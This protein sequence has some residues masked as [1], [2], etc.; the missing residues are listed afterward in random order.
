MPR[1]GGEIDRTWQGFA[2]HF[3][4]SS[5]PDEGMNWLRGKKEEPHLKG[6]SNR[7]VASNSNSF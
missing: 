2:I 7:F 6:V 5:V 1:E 4:L 3:F